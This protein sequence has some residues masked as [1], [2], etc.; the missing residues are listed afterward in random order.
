MPL[1]AGKP[2]PSAPG[3]GSTMPGGMSCCK[4]IEE[5]R[6]EC[7]FE[8]EFEL[9]LGLGLGLELGLGLGMMSKRVFKDVRL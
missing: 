2:L 9:G 6:F 4:Q 1:L 7:K 8:F 5:T 3:M